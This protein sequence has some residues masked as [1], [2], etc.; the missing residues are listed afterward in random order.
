[1]EGAAI[2]D[3]LETWLCLCLLAAVASHNFLLHASPLE[4]LPA[5]LVD[6]LTVSRSLPPTRG[7]LDVGTTACEAA[8]VEGIRRKRSPG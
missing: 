1:M 6:S 8:A 2:L 4:Y 5:W 7:Q 3:S